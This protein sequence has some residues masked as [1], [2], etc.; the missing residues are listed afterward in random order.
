MKGE[1]KTLRVGKAFLESTKFNLQLIDFSIFSV[2]YPESIN[3]KNTWV[4]SRLDVKRHVFDLAKGK[5]EYQHLRGID[6]PSSNLNDI[7]LL[8]DTFFPNMLVNFDF[9]YGRDHNPYAVR[10]KVGWVLMAGRTLKRK[11]INV[12][13]TEILPEIERL[14]QIEGYGALSKT[15]PILMTRD[16]KR[17]LNIVESTTTLKDGRCE[18]G[19]LWKKDI[20]NLPYNRNLA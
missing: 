4:V 5:T 7:T 12:S 14:Y 19:L 10:T 1:E 20:V 13:R 9:R 2:P 8:I 17:A 6:L 16:D 3:I 15:E 18:I 11:I